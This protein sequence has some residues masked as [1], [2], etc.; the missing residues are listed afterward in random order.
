MSGWTPTIVWELLVEAAE[1]LQRL[2][3][4]ARGPRALGS[5][6]PAIVRTTAESFNVAAE[7]ADLRRLGPPSAEAIDRLDRAIVWLEW[8]SGDAQRLVWMR[9][10]GVP[11]W[12]LELRPW[13]LR[14]ERRR[15][16]RATL[17][18]HLRR[19]LMTIAARQTELD[20]AGRRAAVVFPLTARPMH[21]TRAG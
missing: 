20:R 2:P 8:L 1:T 5:S 9:A 13:L 3:D 19:A 16:D 7:R 18:V 14:I 4:A 15:Y 10:C 21:D 17:S 11:W 12:R 6:W